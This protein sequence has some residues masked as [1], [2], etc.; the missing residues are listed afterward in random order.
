ME[1]NYVRL[2]RIKTASLPNE[3]HF[4]FLFENDG[5]YIKF[6]VKALEIESFILKN[7]LK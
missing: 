2:V 3:Q 1:S 7:N 5:L 4:R 6:D